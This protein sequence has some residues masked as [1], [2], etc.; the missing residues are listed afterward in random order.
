MELLDIEEKYNQVVQITGSEGAVRRPKGKD[1]DPD[2]TQLIPQ[3]LAKKRPKD[4]PDEVQ[5]VQQG[6][7]LCKVCND[8]FSSTNALIRHVK[9]FHK[10]EFNFNC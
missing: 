5:V 1:P 8:S 9:R 6:Y 4:L 10:D 2:D 3:K 7:L